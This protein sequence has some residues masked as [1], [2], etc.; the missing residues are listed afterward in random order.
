MTA[1]SEAGSTSPARQQGTAGQNPRQP[2][3]GRF[4]AGLHRLTTPTSLAGL[5]GAALGLLALGP[6]LAPGYLLSYDMVFV[7]HPP[8]SAALLGFTGGPARAVPSDAVI[9]VA[10]HLLPADLVQKIV[11]LLIFVLASSGAAALL[12]A[13]WRDRAGRPAPVLACLAC[14]VFYTWNPFVAERLLIGQWAL[15]L[16]YAGLPWVMRELVTGPARIRPGRLLV[17]MLPA[18][19]GGFAAMAVTGLAA[20]PAALARSGPPAGGGRGR[21][22]VTVLAL[23][24]LLSLPW[25]IPSLMVPVH[26]D[27]AGVNLFAARADT[28]FGRLGSLVMLSGIWN[29]QTVPRGYGGAVSLFWLLVVACALA[30][31]VLVLRSRGV[32]PPDEHRRS[33]RGWPGLGVAGLVG[34]AVAAI[35]ITPPTRAAL[36]Y[37]VTVSPGF[38]ILRDGQQFVAALALT[39]AVG[40]GAAVAWLL[41]RRVAA[42]GRQRAEPAGAI[43]AVLA[44]IAPIILLPGMAWGV[45][46]R[47]RPVQY[48]ADWM[49]ARAIIDSDPRPGSVLVLPW[50][51]Y[52]RY[53]WNNFEAVYDPW[54]KLLSREVISNDGLQVGRQTLSQESAAS[55]RLNRI[56]TRAGPLTSRLRAAGV[57]YVVVDAGPLLHAPRAALDG[58]ARLPGARVILDSRDLVVFELPRPG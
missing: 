15:L 29:D 47:I 44:I 31:Y 13:G 26:T 37:L 50:A 14:G 22:L 39:E 27:P 51:A 30:G 25:L 53:P 9:T 52:R 7:P 56:V 55:I 23:L 16:G 19:I 11:L 45:A 33:G 43:I 42:A 18:A 40:L 20:V 48:P 8:F 12:A 54:N 34:L 35:G 41:D 36:R 49:T 58:Q 21:R 38:A 32:V 3:G 28:P 4:L 1:R 6:G 24:A 46:G 57:V 17:V 2:A 5:I 10:A